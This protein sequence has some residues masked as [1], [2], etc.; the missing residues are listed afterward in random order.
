MGPIYPP[1]Q[2]GIGSLSLGIKRSRVK[3]TTY[4]YT[5]LYSLPNI[6]QAIKSKMRWAGSVA[7]VGKGEAYRGFPWEKLR[8][9]DHLED[10]GIDGRIILR[11][12]FRKSDVGVWT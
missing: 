5:D 4:R 8:E 3:L 7:H 1:I 11:S 6:V 2:L 9:R 10:P 12:I